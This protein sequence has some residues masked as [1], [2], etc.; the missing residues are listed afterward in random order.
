[1]N[2]PNHNFPSIIYKYRNWKSE[3]NRNTLIKSELYFASPK[4]FNDPF[5]CRVPKDFSILNDPAEL[6]LYIEYFRKKHK[7]NYK[8]QEQEFEE[9]LHD[10]RKTIINNLEEY[11]RQQNLALFESQDKYYGIISFS[12]RWDS[13][14]MWSH[15]ADFHRGFCIGFNEMKLRESG[16]FGMGGTVT[17]SSDNAIPLRKLYGEDALTDAFREA[18]VK[19]NEW[20]YEKEYRLTKLFYPLVPTPEQRIVSIPEGSIEEIIIGINTTKADEEEII[21]WARKIDVPVS[22]LSRSFTKFELIK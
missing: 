4:E 18:F 7:H 8:G 11:Q 9:S 12:C 19:A 22:K 13:I 16:K 14:L 20:S 10:T 2:E 15:Y 17:Y 3:F 1:M 21:Y 6:E 5:D